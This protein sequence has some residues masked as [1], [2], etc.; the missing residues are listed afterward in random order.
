MGSTISVRYTSFGLLILEKMIANIGL[1]LS[2]LCMNFIEKA[3]SLSI[4]ATKG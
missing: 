3:K 2:Y 4:E 1:S